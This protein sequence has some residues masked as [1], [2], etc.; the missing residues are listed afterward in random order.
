MNVA[1]QVAGVTSGSDGKGEAAGRSPER[2]GGPCPGQPGAPP[3]RMAKGQPPEKWERR[4]GVGDGNVSKA[5]E[6]VT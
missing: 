2:S 1:R 5:F 3:S 6:A 4:T